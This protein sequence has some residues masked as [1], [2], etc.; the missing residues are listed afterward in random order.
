MGSG[1]KKMTDKQ[2]DKDFV[3]FDIPYR[4]VTMGNFWCPLCDGWAESVPPGWNRVKVSE[5]L[6]A[7]TV[8]LVAP[9]VTS[10][11]YAPL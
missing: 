9:L 6:G 4:D 7:T 11:P 5:N 2:T 10:L 1:F 8:A 3:N